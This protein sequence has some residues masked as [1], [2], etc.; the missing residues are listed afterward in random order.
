MSDIELA[1]CAMLTTCRVTQRRKGGFVLLLICGVLAL[2][3]IALLGQA[4]MRLGAESLARARLERT[5]AEANARIAFGRALLALAEG[6]GQDICASA[7]ANI[8]PGS[9]QPLWSLYESA[10]GTRRYLVSG[11]PED[12]HAATT[13]VFTQVYGEWSLSVPVET[14]R[15]A[16]G[17]PLGRASWW[18]GDLGILP[19]TGLPDGR[20]AEGLYMDLSKT[21]RAQALAQLRQN[22]PGPVPAVDGLRSTPWNAFTLCNA[23]DGGLRQDLSALP[24]AG[25]ESY[26][27]TPPESWTQWMRGATFKAGE[28]RV[29]A[30]EGL[31][32]PVVTEFAFICGIGANGDQYKTQNARCDIILSHFLWVEIWNPFASKLDLGS[33]APDYRVRIRG[34][35]KVT[36]SN[37]AT[38]TMPDPMDIELDCH[39]DMPPGQVQLLSEPAS[40]GGTGNNGVWH[41]IVGSVYWNT[42]KQAAS[43]TLSFQASHPVAEFIYLGEGK[44]QLLFTLDLGPQ[45]AFTLIYKST[46]FCRASASLDRDAAR[47]ALQA[48]LDETEL[49]SLLRE[50]EPRRST[51]ETAADDALVWMPE[52]A[53]D[54]KRG[55]TIAA[56]DFFASLYSYPPYADRY[57]LFADAPPRPPVSFAALRHAPQ[58][59]RPPFS[60]GSGRDSVADAQLD[61]YFF[62]SLPTSGWDGKTALENHRIALALKA[63]AES[64]LAAGP[65]SASKLLLVGG[66]NVNTADPGAWA[67]LLRSL[68]YPEWTGKAST[69]GSSRSVDLGA[70]LFSMPWGAADVRSKATLDAIADADTAALDTSLNPVRDDRRHPAYLAGLRDIGPFVNALAGEIASRIAE[71]GRPF[72][73]LSELATS[74]ILQEAIDAVPSI[75][76]RSGTV[77]GIPRG[78][79]A[80]VD[81][82]LLLCALSPVLFTRSDSYLVRFCGALENGHASVEGEALLQRLPT[83]IED[84]AAKNGRSWRIVQ[85][86]WK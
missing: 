45:P 62:S 63:K 76:R 50:W 37:G 44:E 83:P 27:H 7:S 10:D 86:R 16:D 19:A 78:S 49:G 2:L 79:P 48:K 51:L 12:S 42:S 60:I 54:Y 26:A 68:S 66:F 11:L 14:L 35:P 20:N 5:L 21:D 36:A 69:D 23:L 52:K 40:G 59:G 38:I 33:E 30:G 32:A 73:S 18:A 71:R 61:R 46:E 17:S 6:P 22:L 13:Q 9:A 39:N 81:Q 4:T 67:A 55:N 58:S 43:S 75:N 34:L 25:V 8:V 3:F 28:L 31:F 70:A 41:T 77:D 84:D 72:H 80:H 57:A 53:T 56:N 29:E 74:G 64:T 85:W 47:F 24:A 15:R 1:S 65:D 82:G